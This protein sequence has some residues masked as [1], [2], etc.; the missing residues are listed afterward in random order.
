MS[1]KLEGKVAVITG[2]TTGIGEA[3][4]RLFLQEGATVV[5][6][7]STPKSVEALRA[8][9]PG[10]TALVSDAGD[11]RAIEALVAEVKRRHDGIDVLFLNAG[12]GQFGPIA[13][14][15]EDRFD[16][17]FRVN[18]KGPWLTLKHAGPLL[19]AGGAV[20]LNTSVNNQVG[21]AGTS[22]YAATKAALRSL[23]RT[24]AQEF[25][26]QGVRVNAVSPGPVKTP[27]YDKLGL[28]APAVDGFQA[29]LVA[30]IP[31]KRM[32]LPD[33]IARAALFLASDDSSFM[34]GEELVVDGGFTSL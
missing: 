14:F 30:Q 9:L 12:V 3:T 23:A 13:E 10:V 22:V 33:E 18:F 27:I 26:G 16:E 5:A 21:M 17:L 34:T 6:T 4:A 28:P 19:R 8:R 11:G 32:G 20:V 29:S 7:G 24:A 1:R 31:L 25:V 2:G 15:P